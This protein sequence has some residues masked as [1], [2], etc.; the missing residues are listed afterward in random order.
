MTNLYEIRLQGHLGGDW[1]D[2]FEG[3]KIEQCSDGTTLLT[4]AIPDQA[5]LHGLL[6]NI[7]DLG[8]PLLLVRR[9]DYRDSWDGKRG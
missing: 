3:V 4:G 6:A 9:V 8:I 5:A 2:W 1:S 7:R